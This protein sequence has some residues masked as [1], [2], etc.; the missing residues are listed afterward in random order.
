MLEDQKKQI[1]YPTLF[2]RV[3]ATMMDMLIFSFIFTPIIS[4]INQWIFMSKFGGVLKDKD[5]DLTDEH[6]IM[7]AFQTPE[8]A[9]YVNIS[10]VLDIV[11][12][13]TLIYIVFLGVSFI[14]CWYKFGCTPIK[15]LM[16]MRIVDEKTFEKPKLSNLIWRFFGCSLFIIGIWWMFFTDRRQALHD[17]LGHTVVVKA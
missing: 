9:Q 13:M 7:E 12:P 8:M 2:K 14:G 15:Y 10:S 5:I 11:I 16:G 4:R 17:K 6:A 1:I 3:M